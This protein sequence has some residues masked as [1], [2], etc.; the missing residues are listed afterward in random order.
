VTAT[1][2]R[3][4]AVSAVVFVAL[5][6]VVALV[7][8]R[9]GS[10]DSAERARYPGTH[11]IAARGRQ[12]VDRRTGRA[13]VA[14]GWNYVRLAT[15]RTPAGRVV[16]HS[17]FNVGRYEPARAERALQQ[18]HANGYDVVRVFLNAACFRECLV[19]PETGELSAAYVA[20]LADFLHRAAAA[21]VEVLL[22]IDYPPDRGRYGDLLQA[23][24]GAHAN[25]VNRFYLTDGGVSASAAFWSDLVSA[26]A[27]RS[28]PLRDVVGYELL[29]EVTFA[30]RQQPLDL[31]TGTF[32]TPAG[33][34]YRLARP[35]QRTQMLRDAL[36]YWIDSVRRAIRDVDRTAL[37][38]VGF[39][40]PLGQRSI[41]PG[42]VRAVLERS[43]ADFVDVHAYSSLGLSWKSYA[44]AAGFAAARKPLLMGELGA[45]RAAYPTVAGAAQ[46]LRG[47][48]EESCG[49][50]FAGWLAWPWDARA[51]P[52]LWSATSADGA[53]ERSLAP[54]AWPSPCSHS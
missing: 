53:L 19:D 50:G 42:L 39:A 26:L 37:V 25:G 33:R 22:T 9:V 17:T 40:Q 1:G 13:F 36:A 18:M 10:P 54:D 23:E 38:G 7:A 2:P 6:A 46:A 3:I 34:R 28:A 35:A 4:V 32:T 45:F 31:R 27:R 24:P 48:I 51:Q 41:G 30:H 11:A 43:H 47:R 14:R 20:N 21:D 29:N 52:E 49:Y 8:T 12:L 5:L 15:Q 44:A 16:Y